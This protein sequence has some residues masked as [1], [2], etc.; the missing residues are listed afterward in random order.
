M[1]YAIFINMLT[2]RV[3][4]VCQQELQVFSTVVQV[5]PASEMLLKTWQLPSTRH[6][7]QLCRRRRHPSAKTAYYRKG[8]RRCPK[9]AEPYCFF[10]T[11]VSHRDL[12][13]LPKDKCLR[14][15]QNGHHHN[16][17][18]GHMYSHPQPKERSE[19]V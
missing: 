2:L 15:P 14:K 1:E 7:E 9:V 11:I 17:H 4:R 19:L 8:V 6:F 16:E 12:F 18:I 13:L 3:V 10:Y 5:H